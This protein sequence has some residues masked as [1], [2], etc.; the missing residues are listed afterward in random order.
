M[1]YDLVRPHIIH[2]MKVVSMTKSVVSVALI[3]FDLLIPDFAFTS[4]LLR[5]KT[6]VL[7]IIATTLI[8]TP[9]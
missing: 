9:F 5:L 7:S 1:D 3:H 8:F 4:P 6:L 2:F